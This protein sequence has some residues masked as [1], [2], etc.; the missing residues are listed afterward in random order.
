MGHPLSH[1]CFP[2]LKGTQF[3]FLFSS[4]IAVQFQLVHVWQMSMG[5]LTFCNGLC[6]R[7]C[8]VSL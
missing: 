4:I 6:N 1:E 3:Y 7:Q 2:A 8:K 5:L